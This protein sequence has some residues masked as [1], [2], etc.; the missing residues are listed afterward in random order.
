[1]NT[2]A[3]V[4]KGHVPE[5]IC[6]HKFVYLQIDFRSS[7]GRSTHYVFN[8]YLVL[9]HLFIYFT[10]LAEVRRVQQAMHAGDTMSL[11]QWPGTVTFSGN[12]RLIPR[13]ILSTSAAH[14]DKKQ[15]YPAAS[16]C[17]CK[18]YIFYRTYI[19]SYNMHSWYWSVS[20]SAETIENDIIRNVTPFAFLFKWLYE[21]FGR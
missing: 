18:K 6:L 21:I 19:R 5:V 1:M 12:F 10:Q 9:F 3:Y 15:S 2:P 13:G 7:F 16:V 4:L 14:R 8:F 20:G 11:L 17:Y